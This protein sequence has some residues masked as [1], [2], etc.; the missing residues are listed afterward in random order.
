MARPEAAP[1]DDPGPA[2][3][4]W[5][6]SRP[7][8]PG[9]AVQVFGGTVEQLVVI[10]HAEAVNHYGAIREVP[11]P[12]QL[13]PPPPDFTNRVREAGELRDML[14]T[15]GRPAAL[16]CLGGQ[17]GVG[18][19]ALALAVAEQVSHAF[20]DGQ[21]YADLRND[22]DPTDPPQRLLGAFLN[23]L[24]APSALIPVGLEE[25]ARMY[26]TYTADRSVLVVLDNVW[27]EE[28]VEP[29]V[30]AGRGS[31]VLVTSRRRLL[32]LDGARRMSL[33]VFT[34]QHALALLG[35][36][37]GES[38][39]RDDPT[40]ARAIAALCGHLPLAL[41][42]VGARLSTPPRPS[43][44]WMMRRLL[45]EQQR[46][47]ALN[48]GDRGVRAAYMTSYERLDDRSSRLFRLLGVV[49]APSYAAWA[50]AALLDVSDAVA[51]RTLADLSDQALLEP[52]TEDAA[53]QLRYGF[54]DLLR[55]FAREQAAQDPDQEGAD[56]ALRRLI[57]LACGL[58]AW[59]GLRLMP[60]AYLAQSLDPLLEEL[61]TAA[62]RSDAATCDAAAWLG[63]EYAGLIHVAGLASSREYHDL[64][65]RFAVALQDFC[66]LNGYLVT[67]AELCELATRAADATGDPF[68]LGQAYRCLGIADVYRGEHEDGVAHLSRAV[69]VGEELADR[70]LVAVSL[71]ALGEAHSQLGDAAEAQRCWSTAE[72]LFAEEGMPAWEAWTMW[73]RGA[74]G[75]LAPQVA[76]EQLDRTLR[77]FERMGD[78]RGI[79]VAL[80][81]LGL[82]HLRQGESGRAASYFEQ[83]LPLFR[84]VGDRVGEALAM[85]SL[86]RLYVGSGREAEGI[87]LI[88]ASSPF[89][90]RLGHHEGLL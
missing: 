56:G 72:R 31:A 87:A 53:G 39:I 82:S 14:S 62:R 65:V 8:G 70:R 52:I 3:A 17:P 71:R 64:V 1:A 34:P 73:S 69:Q 77:R 75:R 44:A 15:S 18:K 61:I 37:A 84:A 30:P 5:L 16:V 49:D 66:E 4:D 47:E 81:S 27:T 55:V 23:D 48:I 79:A 67:W 12:R 46:L 28:Q 83:C 6:R 68:A 50:A 54:H 51:E 7:G 59:H 36:I 22:P 85:G 2:L 42:M 88:E 11:P 74:L 13:R 76:R 9:A 25:R 40:H 20:P 43:L 41:R 80:R 38:V 26:R 58:A 89:I 78:T 57:G 90:D 32:A 63:E 24:G 35:R 21:L 10:A 33:E 29:L 45:D 60:D 19:T 86:G